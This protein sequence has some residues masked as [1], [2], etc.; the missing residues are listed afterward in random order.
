MHAAQ[1]DAPLTEAELRTRLAEELQQFTH[2]PFG[3]VMYVFPWGTPLLSKKGPRKWQKKFLLRLKK[4]IESGASAAKV[5]Q[6]AVASGHGI[7]KSTLVA[8]LILWAMSTYRD[9]RGVITANTKGQLTSKTWPELGKW[10]A[11]SI[12]AWMFE[13][14]ATKLYS[15]EAGHADSWC[16]E[17]TPWSIHNT[18]AFAGLHNEG[19]RIIL[20]FDEASAIHD[21]VWEVA[22]GA[23]T[24]EDT[25]I[26][27]FAFGNPTR[28]T[29][30]FREC[31]RRFKDFW[32]RDQIDSRTV[33][34][35][36]LEQIK[37]W[38]KKWG[39]DSDFFRVRVRGLWPKAGSLQFISEIDAEA[40]YG[41]HIKEHQFRF[42]P[43][44]ITVDP[45]WTGNDALIIG[46]RQGLYY[47]RLAVLPKNDNDIFVG[48]LVARLE[49]EHQADGVVIDIGWGTGIYSFGKTNHRE[50]QLVDFGGESPDPGYLN[51]R[52]YMWGK[53]RD[54]LKAGGAI[55][56]DEDPEIRDE[57]CSV[58]IKERVDGKIQLES[59]KEMH[60]RG[61]GSPNNADCLAMS[62]AYDIQKKDKSDMPGPAN[63]TTK[64]KTEYN[65]HGD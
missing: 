29:G 21:K 12:N 48:N 8:W 11:L 14:S 41:R 57:L 43:K 64:A 1:N 7:G 60:D 49:D 30:R 54:W 47:R 36:N 27:W 45:A 25:E 40:A 6:M 2:D 23:L 15:T 31:W 26:F 42:A 17:A 63:S 51:M 46:M 65:P 33:E 62:F 37:K 20:I 56:E 44:I 13:K 4:E 28:N 35:I 5:I 22:E 58:E 61:I 53:M 18:E 19:K 59:K 10:H 9:T 24:D 38:A 39:V 32:V 3:F 55:A 34:G 52:S 50:W 16:V